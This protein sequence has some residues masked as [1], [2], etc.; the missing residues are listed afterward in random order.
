M[1]KKRE[2]SEPLAPTR[3][4]LVKDAR[5]KV[6]I[7]EVE[8]GLHG[9]EKGLA[10]LEAALIALVGDQE[11]VDFE[12]YGGPDAWTAEVRLACDGPFEVGQWA[13]RI[14]ALLRERGAPR[15]GT[16]VLAS[17]DLEWGVN[18]YPQEPA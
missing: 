1:A 2:R 15:K 12:P 10:E 6:I 16:V 14:A 7:Y 5:V 9:G 11:Q 8:K 17:F 13:E 18:V 3:S 4:R